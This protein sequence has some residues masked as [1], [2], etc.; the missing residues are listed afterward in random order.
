MPGHFRF[1]RAQDEDHYLRCV[2]RAFDWRRLG[3]VA[4]V[5]L[6]LSV[7]PYFNPDFLGFFSPAEIVLDWLEHFVDLAVLAAALTVAYTLLDE[8]LQGRSRLRLPI[9]CAM[10]F[11]LS[12][13]LTLLLFAYY[14]HGFDHPPPLLRLLADSLHF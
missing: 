8:A 11:G 14:A 6:L 9:L 12:L 7:G 13:V 5:T 2:V 10:L 3:A 1:P 4:L